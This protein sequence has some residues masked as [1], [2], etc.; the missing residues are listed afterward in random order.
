MCWVR[1]GRRRRDHKGE[2]LTI[3]GWADPMCARRCRHRCTC[4][5]DRGRQEHYRPRRN[6]GNGDRDFRPLLING[7]VYQGGKDNIYG[8][9]RHRSNHQARRHHQLRESSPFS[10][11][12][13]TS[14]DVS[15]THP[16]PWL[17]PSLPQPH[18]NRSLMPQPPRRSS[19]PPMHHRRPSWHRDD[20]FN[21]HRRP[22]IPAMQRRQASWSNDVGPNHCRLAMATVIINTAIR[23]RDAGLVAEDESGNQIWFIRRTQRHVCD[24]FD[25]LED[26]GDW[27][28]IQVEW[29]R[30]TNDGRYRCI[31]I[32]VNHDSWRN[33]PDF[34]VAP[35]DHNLARRYRHELERRHYITLE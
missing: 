23:H 4:C 22:S 9:M 8:D 12:S 27:Q 3:M 30:G 31:R 16:E 32:A 7:N 21:R 2:V 13:H 5:P 19:I 14:D 18:T 1:G 11:G 6:S 28:S 25:D 29:L 35:F 34:M 20:Q 17:P 24:A 33:R 10:R 26:P 15:F